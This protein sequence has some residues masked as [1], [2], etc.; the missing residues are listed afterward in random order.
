VENTWPVIVANQDV[1]K[2][3]CV[4]QRVVHRED[5]TA[6]DAEDVGDAQL[7]E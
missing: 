2:L 4:H 1:P 7:L 6:R 3:G 5:R